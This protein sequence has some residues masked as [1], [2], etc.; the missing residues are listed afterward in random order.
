MP[1]E[2]AEPTDPNSKRNAA[3]SGVERTAKKPRGWIRR[4]FRI[5]LWIFVVLAIF[6]RP[7]FHTVAR[8]A[9]VK[10]A[11]KQNVKLE[12]KFSGSIFT[13]LDV[14][15]VTAYPTGAAPSPVEKITI[16]SVHLEYSIPRLIRHGVGE[17]LRSYEIKN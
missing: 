14:R 8:L 9:L 16:E 6:H 2:E 10:I 12:V 11:A 7:L 17:F 13:N 15:D 5:L 4:I 3:R 1:Q